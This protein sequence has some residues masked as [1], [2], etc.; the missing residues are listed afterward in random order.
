MMLIEIEGIGEPD[1]FHYHVDNGLPPLSAD[2]EY[3]KYNDNCLFSIRKMQF[4]LNRDFSGL[5][6][7]LHKFVSFYIIGCFQQYSEIAVRYK[8]KKN[9]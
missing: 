3:E 5:D 9:A 4:L 8:K 1:G 6:D 7:K 2:A